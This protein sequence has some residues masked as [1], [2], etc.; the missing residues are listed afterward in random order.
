MLAQN[1]KSA[2]ELMISEDE[3][4]ALIQVLGM[5][6]RNELVHCNPWHT[7]RRNGF[8]MGIVWEEDDCGSIGCIYGWATAL[9]KSATFLDPP[10][11]VL[12]LFMFGDARRFDMPTE[13]AAMGLRNFLTAGSANWDEVVRCI[14]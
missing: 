11:A 8:N 1:F 3:R 10:P 5:L 12:K 2:E 14:K 13:E 7:S 6:E 9:N 4:N